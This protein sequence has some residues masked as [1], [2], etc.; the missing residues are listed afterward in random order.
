[1]PTLDEIIEAIR[2]FPGVTR[3]AR[4]HEVVDLLPVDGFS[5]VIASE[6]EDAAVIAGEGDNCTLFA[7]DGIME[8]LVRSDPYMAGYF[9][10]LVNVNDIAAMGGRAT[11]MVDIMSMPHRDITLQNLLDER[12]MEL[13]WE[14]WRRQDLIRFKKFE[15][16]FNGDANDP[17][18]DESDGHT[19]LYPIPAD[20]MTLNHNM[21]Q[22]PGY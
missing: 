19:A 2:K 22:N 18:V 17:K 21:V 11:A 16:L 5:H 3:K 13:C 20:V 7:A 15:S 6:G 8:S 9:A 10:V 1:M 12:L 4:I 14:G